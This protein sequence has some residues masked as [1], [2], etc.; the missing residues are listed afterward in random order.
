VE[1]QATRRPAGLVAANL[2]LIALETLEFLWTAKVIL[3]VLGFVNVLLFTADPSPLGL[4]IVMPLLTL[5]LVLV[6]RRASVPPPRER[7]APLPDG[8]DLARGDAPML[9][10]L[11]RGASRS[12]IRRIRISPAPELVLDR[13]RRRGVVRRTL[14]VGYPLLAAFRPDEFRA[15][16]AG[17]R[18]YDSPVARRLD[19][20]HLRFGEAAA[21]RGRLAESGGQM[22]FLSRPFYRWFNPTFERAVVALYRTRVARADA[23]AAGVAGVDAAARAL[24]KLRLVSSH[25][26]EEFW[27]ELWLRTAVEPEPPRDVF[28]SMTEQLANLGAN[29][30]CWRWTTDGDTSTD[31]LGPRLDA[32]GR[33]LADV[34]PE[35]LFQPEDRALPDGELD[36]LTARL[37]DFWIDEVGEEWRVSATQ[38]TT[39]VDDLRELDL[40]AWADE[41][42]TDGHAQHAGLIELHRSPSEALS[43]Y[44]ALLAKNEDDA[45]LNFHVGR[46]RLALG[47]DLR[48]VVQLE[49]AMDLD[50]ELTMPSCE[51]IEYHLRAA[52]K[53]EDASRYEERR[54]EY[55]ERCVEA[56]RD[57]NW[58]HM[59]DPLEPHD[60]DEATIAAI[61]DRAAQMKNVRAVYMAKK[62]VVGFPGEFVYVAMVMRKQPFWV[63]ESRR[64]DERHAREAYDS[65]PFPEP[66]LVFS[67]TSDGR[68][69][70]N[71]AAVRGAR[72]YA[73]RRWRAGPGKL[74]TIALAYIAAWFATAPLVAFTGPVMFPIAFVGATG[75][76]VIRHR[77]QRQRLAD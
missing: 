50:E 53:A 49:R 57:A 20:A 35:T 51:L 42:D 44:E 31:R 9:G 16:M 63:V 33:S 72:V 30:A 2:K 24:V 52:G 19:S 29:P 71:V 17:A 54:D 21:L 36:E 4:K 58:L 25:A 70:R 13:R 34:D 5:A 45:M 67:M 14:V 22:R 27:P 7:T 1:P 69:W 18:A 46:L 32:L 12:P 59:D 10:E 76:L 8:L 62:P 61:R 60:L 77:R 26:R 48:G 43:R 37:T 74:Q 38:F 75:F 64:A 56:G 55:Y 15:L 65:I 73:G 41:L 40:A 3:V 39:S 6:V 11:V 68:L 23:R 47:G 66:V 28:A